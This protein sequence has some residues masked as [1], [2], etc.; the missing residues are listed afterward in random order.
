MSDYEMNAMQQVLMVSS[1]RRSRKHQPTCM[2]L[3]WVRA[4]W[5]TCVVCG[6]AYLPQVRKKHV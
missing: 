3:R 2:R 4:S 1:K 6:G 5:F